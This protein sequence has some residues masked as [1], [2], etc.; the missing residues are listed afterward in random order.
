M[1]FT[2]YEAEG[3][4]PFVEN[5]PLMSFA[6]QF[7]SVRAFFITSRRR[8]DRGGTGNRGPAY[9]SQGIGCGKPSR[10]SHVSDHLIVHLD[11]SW[12]V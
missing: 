6:Y 12:Y 7:L 8:R 4:K 5:S 3:I 2:G 9:P 10:D 1:K 11:D